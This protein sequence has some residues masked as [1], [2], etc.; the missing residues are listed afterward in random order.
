MKK[1]LRSTWPRSLGSLFGSILFVLAIRWAL[2]EPYVIPSGSML[3]TLQIR[4]HI[5]VNKFAYGIRVPFSS[6]Y[7]VRFGLPERGEVVVF[8]SVTN[9]DV[10]VVKRVVGLPGDKLQIQNGRVIVNGKPLERKQT[11]ITQAMNLSDGANL[12]FES[13]GNKNHFV[14]FNSPEPG[15]PESQAQFTEDQE[16]TVPADH[17][18]MMGDNR[19]HSDDSRSWGSLPIERVLGRASSIWLSCEEPLPGTNQLC[20]PDTIRWERLFTGIN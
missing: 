13:L 4:D 16:F 2:F 14:A 10:F 5:L 1:N 8:R 12:Y 7:L 19:D 17:I 3:P 15:T 18:F 9:N 11:E 20:N 6:K